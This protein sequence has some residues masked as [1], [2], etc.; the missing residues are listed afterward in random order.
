[1]SSLIMVVLDLTSGLEGYMVVLD[2]V[3]VLEECVVELGLVHELGMVVVLF[4]FV[5]IV[6]Y[7]ALVVLE[8]LAE[9]GQVLQFSQEIYKL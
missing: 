2:L 6:Q 7:L 1:M 3:L 5:H 9:E 8:G 4:L